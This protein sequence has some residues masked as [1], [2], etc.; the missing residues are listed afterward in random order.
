[1]A[2]EQRGQKRYYY[3][4][5]RANGR[6][7]SEYCGSDVTGQIT[8]L[9]AQRRQA[10]RK[11]QREEKEAFRRLERQIDDVCQ[12][13]GLIRNALLVANGYHRHK[14]QWRKKRNE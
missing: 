9:E 13:I 2:W 8:E 3:R 1:M 10:E 14:G 4:K 6:V 12:D 7:I 5:K 11:A